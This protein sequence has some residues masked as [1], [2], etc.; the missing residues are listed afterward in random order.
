MS[1]IAAL[2]ALAALVVAGLT[3]AIDRTGDAGVMVPPPESVAESFFRQV[4]TGRYSRAKPFLARELADSTPDGELERLLRELERRAGRIE[5]IHGDSAR[6]DGRG[7]TAFMTIAGSRDTVEL[8]L[9]LR[10]EQRVWKIGA[11]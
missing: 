7:A 10:R 2:V 1:R 6:H 4:E 3:T 8:E 5:K 11:L 9:R